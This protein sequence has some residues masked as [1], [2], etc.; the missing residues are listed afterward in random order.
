MK[1]KEYNLRVMIGE[2]IRDRAM[3]MIISLIM[4]FGLFHVWKSMLLWI[5][6]NATPNVFEVVGGVCIVILLSAFSI[7]ACF[8]IYSALSKEGFNSIDKKK[9]KETKEKIK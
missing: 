4:M 7:V 5:N 6:A 3:V 9:E 2:E 1:Q 8:G